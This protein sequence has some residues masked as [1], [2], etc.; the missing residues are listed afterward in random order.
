MERPRWKKVWQDLW[1]N[2]T[3]TVLAVLSIAVGVFA[4]GVIASSF[5]IVRRDMAADYTA[6]NPHTARI[7]SQDF[8][9]E[10]LAE[11]AGPDVVALEGRYNLWVDIAAADGRE[12]PINLN[13]IGPLDSIRVDQLL[14]EAGSRE[15]ADGQIFLERQ[16][17]SGLGLVPG[18]TVDLLLNDGTIH[19]LTIAGTVHD[20]QAN[21]F[22][23]SSQTAGFVT[24]ATM[25]ELGGSDLHNFVNLVTAGPPT[26][27]AHVRQLA[28][29]VA[30]KMVAAGYR[31]Y[32]VNVNRPG[33]HPAQMI[34]DTVLVLMGALGVLTVFL[35]GF[36]I[37]STIAALMGQQVRQIGVMKAV[38]ATTFQVLSLYLGLV[39]AFGL[40]ALLVAVP[41]AALAAFGLSQWL[42]GML[43][44]NASPFTIPRFSLALQLL[45]GL[46]VPV[47]AALIPVLGG[48]RLTVRQAMTSYGL[49]PA[50]AP[51]PLD[52]LIESVRGLPRPL[53][54]SLRNTFRRKGRLALT[55]GTLILGGAIFIAVFSVR[56]SLFAEIDQTV[57]YFQADVNV[58][59]NRPYALSDLQAAVSETPGVTAVEGWIVDT[60][61]V[62]QADGLNSDLVYLFAP[63]AGSRLVSPVMT[64]GR[65]LV[66]TDERAIVVD[67]HFIDLRPEVAVG[68]SLTLILDEQDV[69]FEVVG[70]FRLAGTVPGPYIYVN[71]EALSVLQGMGGQANSLRVVTASREP[72]GQ[73]AVLADMKERLS[74]AGLEATLQTGSELIDQQRYR[75]N[76]LIS[77]LLVMGVLIATVGGLGLMGTMSM[78]VLERTREIGVMRSIGAQNR[79]IFQIVLVE[80]LLI[81]LLSWLLSLVVAIPITLLLDDR[82]GMALMTVPLV[83]EYS[84]LGLTIWLVV[85]LMVATVAGLLPARNAVRLTVRDVLAY[86]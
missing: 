58:S 18:D 73:E 55:L 85:V 11:L 86:E 9:D 23:F 75:I 79:A 77:L 10:L 15:L 44:A 14:F 53:L 56:E 68:D 78:N 41:L 67:N 62:L 1:A 45:I 74:A 26:D 71:Y 4:V 81:G 6:T 8:P 36:L 69:A 25:A 61:N 59:F 50:A 29:R 49:N 63:P 60:A 33:Q 3:R 21:P 30:Q 35:S 47:L 57:S 27:A 2:K 24:P 66:P 19:R 40:L 52:R 72:A 48:A 32:N 16:G 7:Y 43:N 64:A 54:L 65:W 13:S 84:T 34:I 12:Y 31:V 28:E 46:V 38:G 51:G 17:A 83:Y 5:D 76:L 80:G 82:M 37:T 42:I 22:N 70:I 39:L 20:V